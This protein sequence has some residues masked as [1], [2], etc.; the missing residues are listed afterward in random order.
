MRRF[1]VWLAVGALG[2]LLGAPS[3]AT[4]QGFSVNEHGSCSM[5]RAGTG[6]ASPCNDGSSMVYN[7]AG[8]T[9]LKKGQTQISAGGTF[10]A[11]RGGFE[12]DTGGTSDL[13]SKTYPVPAFYLSHGF[14][15]K[16]AAGIGLFAPYGLSSEW[17]KKSNGVLFPG[18]FSSYKSNIRNIY[19]QP[20]VAYKIADRISLGAGFDINM[21]HLELRQ[22]L[23]LSE[24]EVQPG[25][26]FGN[27]GIAYGT[28]FADGTVPGDATSYGF[29]LGT[30]ID[31]TDKIAIGFRYLSRHT[32]DVNDGKATFNQVNTGIILPAGNPL[33]APA[34]TPLDAILA[35]EFQPGATLSSQKGTTSLQLPE[36]Y[37]LGA[38]YKGHRPS[39]GSV[40]LDHDQLGG[41]GRRRV[42][43]PARRDLDA[44]TELQ[45]ELRLPNRRRVRTRER[46][47]HTGGI[48]HPQRCRAGSDR[49]ADPAR[50][51]SLRVHRRFRH[52]AGPE[53]AS[54]P[55]LPVHRPG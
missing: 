8:L 6:V 44:A 19:I 25:V 38:A 16:F 18:R 51:G 21:S 43:V 15:E 40:R 4:A 29:H 53:W 23:D 28:D 54:R 41:L 26:T 46:S 31:V 12:A 14:S 47:R 10:I 52:R 42:E 11:P 30:T 37:T 9:Q 50:R 49:D 32:V 24:V 1:H 7:P 22:R 33:G 27:L 17:V 2:A 35:A 55:G 34:G 36:Q 3:L 48:H 45:E 20:T 13:E 39:L 5:G